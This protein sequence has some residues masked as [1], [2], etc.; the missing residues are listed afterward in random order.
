MTVDG[1]LDVNQY[2]FPDTRE[3]FATITGGKK[4]SKLDLSEA[5]LQLL[6]DQKSTK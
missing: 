4:F 5:Y 3:F 1:A 2:P 6:P